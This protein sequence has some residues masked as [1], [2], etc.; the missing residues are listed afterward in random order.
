MVSVQ[1]WLLQAAQRLKQVGIDAAHL[2]ARVLAGHVL[3]VEP[4]DVPLLYSRQLS[5]EELAQLDLLLDRRLRREPLQYIL[6]E[7]HFWTLTLTVTNQ[8]L[9]PRPETEHLVEAVLDYLR[10]RSVE[11]TV[12]GQHIW[13]GADLGTGSGA[14]P[15]ALLSE[16]DHLFMYAVDISKEALTVAKRNAVAY[17]L[18]QRVSFLHGSWGTPLIKA[19][20]VGSLDFIVSN[21]PYIA[22][23]ELHMLQ[24]EVRWFEPQQ[25]L[26]GG[27][28][29]LDAYRQIIPGAG[30]LLKPD[31]LLVLEVSPQ[32]A[33][34]VL[35]M[36]EA[37]GRFDQPE[38][39]RD[40]AGLFRVVTA[41]KRPADS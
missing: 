3:G 21:P 30:Q 19:G 34:E 15:L 4:A 13:R 17:G 28:D 38:T 1:E 24:P 32:G 27:S 6:G 2:E 25:A 23:A 12:N 14:I 39:K 8:V 40:Y 20:L 7:A 37:D 29:G 5:E 22:Q 33:G 31:G 16:V 36:I 10:R 9:I 18:H 35:A 11:V 41:T 26:L